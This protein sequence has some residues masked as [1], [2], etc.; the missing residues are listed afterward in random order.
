MRVTKCS[1]CRRPIRPAPISP[2]LRV[3][4]GM[5]GAFIVLVFGF[6]PA[7]Q[8]PNTTGRTK[9]GWRG[10]ALQKRSLL[11]AHRLPLLARRAHGRALADL[12][13]RHI[14]PALVAW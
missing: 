10:Q 7:G 8:K 1:A 13:D 9:H 3:S 5:S 4:V 11:R 14:P 2:M 6:C 12:G